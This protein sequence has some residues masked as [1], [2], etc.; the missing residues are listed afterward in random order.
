MFDRISKLV[1]SIAAAVQSIVRSYAEIFFLSR[2]AVGF[3]LVVCTLL[4]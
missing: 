3:V 4:N 2:A 1:R